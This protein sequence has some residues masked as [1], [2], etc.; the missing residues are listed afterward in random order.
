VLVIDGEDALQ[1]ERS[2]QAGADDVAA[3]PVDGST[4][5]AIVRG[6]LRITDLH[7][8]IYQLEGAVLTL[9]RAVED[10]DH[11][12]GGNAEKVAHWAIQLGTALDL[13]EDQ[14]TQLYKAALLHD[15][16]SVAVP[17]EVLTKQAGLEPGEYNTVKRHPLV[18]VE[19]LRALPGSAVLLPAI[20]HHHE[21]VDGAGYP[22]GVAGDSI[23]LFARIIA[24][25]DAFVAMRSDRPYRPRRSKEEAVRILQQGAGHQWDAGLV[26]RFLRL[27][28]EGEG[29]E[30]RVPT[31]G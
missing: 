27:V 17:V 20:R 15:V 31:A 7:A 24:I 10:R 23:P 2:I 3:R 22:D 19:I 25:A 5:L 29:Q 28:V 26:G 18:G 12:S 13:P 4:L 1:A 16:G 30:A 8:Q 11:S 9:A 6:Q 21:R 14:L